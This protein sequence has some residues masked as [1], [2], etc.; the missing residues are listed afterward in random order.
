MK[1]ILALFFAPMLLAAS[2]FANI[3]D[4]INMILTPG[5]E[6]GPR[7]CPAQTLAC[8]TSTNG[9]KTLEGCCPKGYPNLTAPM[10][11]HGACFDNY[12]EADKYAKDHEDDS[13]GDVVGCMD[14]SYLPDFFKK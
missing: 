5:D 3:T 13:F 10:F 6:T 1:K 11:G 14:Q 9:T 4:E 7:Y 8:V 2:S 12:Q